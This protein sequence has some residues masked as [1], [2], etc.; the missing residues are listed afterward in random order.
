MGKEEKFSL[1]IFFIETRGK[2]MSTTSTLFT[3][4]KKQL[5]T[6][7]S[8]YLR[9]SEQSG[10]TPTESQMKKKLTTK[11]EEIMNTI[12]SSG[13]YDSETKQTVKNSIQ[14]YIE[15]DCMQLYKDSLNMFNREP[16][17]EEPFD[18]SSD[19]KKSA[20]SIISDIK[21]AVKKDYSN[22]LQNI[23]SSGN[24]PNED[25]VNAYLTAKANTYV[26]EKLS[27]LDSTTIQYAKNQVMSAVNSCVSVYN[28]TIKNNNLTINNKM[29]SDT[30]TESDKQSKNA[31]QFN[32]DRIKDVYESFSGCDMVCTISITLPGEKVAIGNIVVGYL[33][34]LS[35]S[36]HQDKI[37]VRNIGNMNAKDYTFGPRT[38]AGSL[39][40]ALFNKHWMYDL[41]EIYRKKADIATTNHF[42][43]DEMPPFDITIT[44]ANEYGRK[45]RMALYGVRLLNE[46]MVLSINDLYTENTY[47]YVATNIDYFA[48]TT[49]LKITA[50]MIKSINSNVSELAV[51]T[52]DT[53]EISNTEATS[54]N[55]IEE[56]N[57][58]NEATLFAGV[59][60]KEEAKTVANEE[61][62]RL[63]A[64][65]KSNKEK[66]VANGTYTMQQYAVMENKIRTTFDVYINEYIPRSGKLA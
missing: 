3:N 46:G 13:D 35:Y 45:A 28:E 4:V 20:K 34:T 40:F 5:N 30:A 27:G 1:P 58:P 23:V 64:I 50:N 9:Q 63:L 57:I 43:V 52:R 65:N 49:D 32:A 25:Q 10:N 21:K 15:T 66:G 33:Q 11:S 41:M 36:V 39:V 29:P 14:N 61:K 55:E 56:I 48:D 2:A 6:W 44:A 8:S 31:S 37:P 59:K 16:N 53:N 24:V 54:E 22:L 62:N 38:I 60:T 47:Q 17:G 51:E 7:Y 12:L 42:L 19:L 18:V 26:N